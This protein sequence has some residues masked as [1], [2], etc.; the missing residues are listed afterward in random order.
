MLYLHKADGFHGHVSE[1]RSGNDETLSGNKRRRMT[2][3]E[4]SRDAHP[5]ALARGSGQAHIITGTIK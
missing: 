4:E 3:D 1:L 5:K 2:D